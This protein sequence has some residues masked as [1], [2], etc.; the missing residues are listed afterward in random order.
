MV[1]LDLEMPDMSGFEV[2]Q[3]LQA[4][5][6]GDAGHPGTRVFAL[7]GRGT[8]DDRRRTEAAGFDAHLVKPL[9]VEALCRALAD[10]PA[11]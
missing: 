9:T 1:L 4:R 3:A 2:L 11:S 8:S 7:T 6:A 10:R 5:E